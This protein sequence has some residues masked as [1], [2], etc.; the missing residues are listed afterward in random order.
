[1]VILEIHE[2]SRRTYGAP[3]VHAELRRLDQHCSRKRVARLMRTSGL[4]G[5]HARRR[6]RRGRPDVAP[7]PD[8]VNRHFTPSGPD[9]VWA[10]DVTQFRTHEGWL[11]LA[12]VIDLWSRR[13]VGW[14]MSA[15]PNS[16]LVTDALLMAFQR[17]RP[18]RRVVHHSDRG[19]AYTSLAFSQRV[20]ELESTSPSAPPATATTTPPS[21]PSGPPSNANSA[22]ST[23]QQ[24]G[25]TEPSFA[26]R[27]STTSKASTTRIAFNAGSAIKA[28]PTT[29]NTQPLETPC[30][31]KRVNSNRQR[32]S[33]CVRVMGALRGASGR[34]ALASSSV[35]G[36]SNDGPTGILVY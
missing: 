14:S 16:E 36:V 24:P 29:N 9:Q 26:A 10:A 27:S 19:A 12:A 25:R 28:P 11:H 15:S 7:A 17:R 30:P 34:W 4:V 21:K 33:L 8:L 13:I 35:D 1:V 20:G 23:T 5:V 3:R 2:R 18:D 22:G 6:W 31:P 32:P